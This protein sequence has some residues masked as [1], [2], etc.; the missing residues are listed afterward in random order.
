MIWIP[1]SLPNRQ[2][3]DLLVGF[4]HVLELV[5]ALIESMLE[6]GDPV[7]SQDE[8]VAL[9][10]LRSDLLQLLQA[11]ASVQADRVEHRQ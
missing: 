4:H 7:G 11:V 2:S 8:R 6:L 10:P 9:L 5:N 3:L 1:Y